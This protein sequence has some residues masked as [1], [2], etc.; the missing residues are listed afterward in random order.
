ML[1]FFRK[2]IDKIKGS[3]RELSLFAHEKNILFPYIYTENE[4]IVFQN[5]AFDNIFGNQTGSSVKELFPDLDLRLNVGHIYCANKR[6]YKVYIQKY[7]P[8]KTYAYMYFIEQD[9][10]KLTNKELGLGVIV[11]IMLIDN[12]EDVIDST[13]EIRRPLLTALIDRRINSTIH[14]IDGIVRKFEKDR[15]ITVFPTA[16]LD[17]LRDLNFEILDQIRSIDMGNQ[18]PVTL[19]VGIGMEPANLIKSMEYARAALDLAL[20]RGG[21]QV[22]IKDANKYYFYGGK[23]KELDKNT[24]VRA[25][26]KAY[27]LDELIEESSN[28][29]IMGHRN[30]DPD[31]LGSG[32]G[33]FRIAYNLGKPVNIILNT[34][35]YSIKNLLNSI[36]GVPEYKEGII[37]GE[38]ARELINENTL[39]IVVDTHKPEMVEEPDA[40]K[41]TKKI[42]VFDHH[43]KSAE[44][45]DNPV[46]TYHEAYASSTSELITEILQYSVAAVKL[47]PEEADALLAGITIDTKNFSVKTGARTFEAAAYLRRSG[48]DSIRVRMMFRSDINTYKAK[49]RA[50][51]NA[52]I[53]NGRIALS[54]CEGSI[55]NPGLIAAK[56]ANEL[57]D[58]EGIMASF[59]LCKQGEGIIISARSLAEI[60]VQVI[61]EKFGGGGHQTVAGA[62]IKGRTLE[63]VLHELRETIQK[64]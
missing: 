6:Y 47:M 19:S 10:L 20:G 23:I 14:K 56:A 63:D 24:R 39:I 2:G 11:G 5:K 29:I 51:N 59:V 45:I 8:S 26:V 12:Y 34:V 9:E 62:Q 13:E 35:P 57:L 32:I 21:D 36:T 15:Y 1:K 18:I 54:V 22:L 46:L 43:R 37:S 33:I 7:D 52:E 4:R 28:V 25:R 41:M 27:A 17:Y 60:N 61:M 16:K 38:K 30:A 64:L 55:E 48:A 31:S 58:I 3:K 50:V 40:L 53:I 42:V 49:T 44:F